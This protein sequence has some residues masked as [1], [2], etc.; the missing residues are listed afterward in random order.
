MRD[1]AHLCAKSKIL[2]SQ[3]VRRKFSDV[4]GSDPASQR[5]R[6]LNTLSSASPLPALWQSL[7]SLLAHHGV[8]VGLRIVVQI[9][10]NGWDLDPYDELHHNIRNK[11]EEKRKVGRPSKLFNSAASHSSR[12]TSAQLNTH[13]LE[14]L[15]LECLLCPMLPLLSSPRP[16]SKSSGSRP[17]TRLSST[18]A[19]SSPVWR[20][21][22]PL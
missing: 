13:V 19:S 14:S 15:C 3:K 1:S 6:N 9:S 2:N 4:S 7:A 22:S 21:S 17:C 16:L 8:A 5:C 10:D 12:V 20:S 11:L 18:V